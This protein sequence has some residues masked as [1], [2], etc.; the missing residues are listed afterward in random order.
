M[1]ITIDNQQENKLL[2]RT[3]ITATMFFEGKTPARKDV[4]K[5]IATQTKTKESL[6]IIK[7]IDTHFGNSKAIITAY[8]YHNENVML[9]IER[10]NLIEK[11]SGHAEEKKEKGAEETVEKEAEKEKV[12]DAKSK[13]DNTEEKEETTPAKES[14]KE[15]E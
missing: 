11:H 9:T 13:E 6:I 10:K 7:K 14:A 3:E 1:D 8:L 15:E 4:Q 2:E 5:A 12:T